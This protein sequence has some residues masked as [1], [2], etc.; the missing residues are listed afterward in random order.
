MAKGIWRREGDHAVPVGAASIEYFR[1]LKDGEEFIAETKGARNIKQLKLWWKLC[2]LVLLSGFNSEMWRTKDDVAE[3][4]KYALHHVKY[5]ADEYGI[6]HIQTASISVEKL[7][8]EKFDPIFKAAV[9]KI[10][11]W[12]QCA[13]KDLADQFFLMT[14]DKVY[15]EMIRNMRPMPR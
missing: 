9:D 10:L 1:A 3:G 5:F 12:L 13:P 4:L 11:G 15:T 2:E 8:Q 6:L 14:G 7:S